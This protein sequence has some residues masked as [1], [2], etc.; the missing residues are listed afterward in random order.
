MKLRTF[1]SNFIGTELTDEQIEIVKAI[2]ENQRVIIISGNGVGK[3][4]TVANVM[5]AFLLTNPDSKV[6]GTSGSYDQ[7][8]DAVWNPMCDLFEKMEE[9]TSVPG[10]I[11]EY[12]NT[13]KIDRDWYAKILSPKDA[14]DLEGRHAKSVM[15]AI[16][17]ADKEYIGYD[18]FE[19]ATSSITDSDDC[20]V[21]IAN[22]PEQRSGVVWDKMMSDRWKT[23][24][25]SSLDSHNVRNKSQDINALLT[26]EE[27][28]NDYREWNGQE[29][30]GLEDAREVAEII[31]GSYG[32]NEK[33]SPEEEEKV[34]GLADRWYRRRLGV[35][36]PDASKSHRPFRTRHVETSFSHSEDPVTKVEGIGID[37]A[38]SGGDL[39]V[40]TFYDGNAI[41]VVEKWRGV[42]HN[43]NESR[44]RK[45]IENGKPDKMTPV[46]IDAVGEGSG[47]ADRLM[48]ALPKA[49]RFSAKKMPANEDKYRN[50]WTEGLVELG[51]A[52]K[53][54]VEFYDADLRE[55][56]LK[57]SHSVELEE[58]YVAS[59][60]REV[61]KAS[62]KS[63]I[64]DLLGH[65]PDHLDAAMM[66]VWISEHL[67]MIHPSSLTW[68]R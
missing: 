16:E 36:P 66:A 21:A 6:L 31:K 43:K 38:R 56:L 49:H 48:E 41:H 47:L 65:S 45:L 53:S 44:I 27:V 55:E 46:C 37:V 68:G 34:S 4:F 26:Y 23:M 61:E 40:V 28:M 5:L 13:L 20:V 9:G 2:E 64:K 3:S 52:L 59:R 67:E 11:Y 19:S 33:L 8:K 32:P 35:I 54:G 58:K 7:F 63:D 42:D 10:Q 12:E 29:W 25:F 30:P 22:P 15:V 51:E 18:H 62:S 24:W 39:N 50:C 57:A 60:D 1:I 17:E 14:G